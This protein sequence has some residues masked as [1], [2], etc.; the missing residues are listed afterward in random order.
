MF[1]DDTII[2]MFMLLILVNIMSL[3]TAIRRNAERNALINSR[4]LVLLEQ[5]TDTL[6]SSYSS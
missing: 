4:I 1:S 5:I 6:P 2:D 3:M